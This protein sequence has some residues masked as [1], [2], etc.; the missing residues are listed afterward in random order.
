MTIVDSPDAGATAGAS[1]F[2]QDQT[3]TVSL[4]TILTGEDAGGFWK[5]VSTKPAPV[6]LFDAAAASLKLAGLPPGD[7]VFK[8]EILG[9][10]GCPGDAATVAVTM[11][12]T[13]TAIAGQ[14]FVLTCDQP[15]TILGSSLNGKDGATLLWVETSHNAFI[16]DPTAD[17]FD[18]AEPGL[19]LLTAT[20]PLT[21]CTGT[22]EAEVMASQN[23]ITDVFITADD[24]SCHGRTDGLIRIDSIEGGSPPLKISMNG[25]TAGFAKKFSALAPGVFNLVITDKDGCSTERNVELTDPPPLTVELRGDTAIWCGDSV[26]LSPVISGGVDSISWQWLYETHPIPGVTTQDFWAKPEKHGD[27]AIKITDGN[28]CRAS[29]S[30]RILVR[31]EP[32]IYAPNVFKPGSADNGVFKIYAHPK[33]QK[34]VSLRVYDRNG[35]LL[36]EQKDRSPFD[37]DFGWDG[38]FNGNVLPPAA[39]AWVAE[40]QLCDHKTKLLKGSVT[41]VR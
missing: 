20:D 16:A 31:D 24:P 25:G 27:F 9:V 23:Y 29:A 4:S 26:F 38:T 14:D 28:G 2:C 40:V 30:M 37:A 1:V 3:T 35:S 7:Y 11:G 32:P 12:K 36:F 19:Y 6:G 8:Y 41:L 34:V 22:D 21:G 5:D 39:F 18:V 33:I 17:Q 13:P 15:S 10:A